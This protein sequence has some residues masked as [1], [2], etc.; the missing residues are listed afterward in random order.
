MR[1]L[2]HILV[3]GFVHIGQGLTG[4][5]RNSFNVKSLKAISKLEWI[6]RRPSQI[7]TKPLPIVYVYDHCPFCVRVRLALGLK[8]IKHKVRFLANDDIDTPTSLVGM[9]IAP[10]FEVPGVKKATAESMDII[11]EIDN[12]PQYGPIHFFRPLSARTDI[13]EWQKKAAGVNRILQRP[14]GLYDVLLILLT[15]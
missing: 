7:T 11:R 6:E 12:N 15:H 4:F 13:A 8:N 14:R 9:K 1:T 2:F 5:G 3:L 10:I